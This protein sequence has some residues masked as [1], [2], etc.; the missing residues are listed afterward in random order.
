MELRSKSGQV[1][2]G[3]IRFPFSI[4]LNEKEIHCHLFSTVSEDAIRKTQVNQKG[5][6]L[7]MTHQHSTVKMLIC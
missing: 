6:K 3:L 5:L 2:T 7:N 1:T 4:I